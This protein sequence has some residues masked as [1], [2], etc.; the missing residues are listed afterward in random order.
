MAISRAKTLLQPWTPGTTSAGTQG[1]TPDTE[2][3][4]QPPSP[5]PWE[6]PPAP[7]KRYRPGLDGLRALAII[8]V[9]LYH[10]GV[11]WVPGGLLG[12]DLF[13]VVSGFLITS[14]LI[15]EIQKTGRI[16]LAAFYRRR[17]LRLLPALALVLVVTSLAL[18]LF[19]PREVARFR[20][21]LVAS[22]GYV[23]N[24][25]FIVRHQSYF[26]A[27][28]RPSPFQHLWS[29]AVE[30]Q[31]Y[32]VAPLGLLALRNKFSSRRGLLQTAALAVG[33]ACASAVVMAV[34][35][36]QHNL[37]YGAD[38]S[39]VYFGTDTHAS[40]LLIGVAAAALLAATRGS[41]WQLPAS[42]RAAKALDAAGLASLAIMV[43][44]MLRTTEFSPG[45]YRGGFWAFS[46]VAGVAAVAVSRPGGRLESALGG[47]SLRWVG[48]RSYGLY[49]WHWPVFVFTR[50]QLDVPFAGTADVVLRL[51]L[52]VGL[53]EASYRL[54]ERPIR[55]T[56]VRAWLGA[57]ILRGSEAAVALRASAIQARSRWATRSA[58]VVRRL[59]QVP[60]GQYFFAGLG[61]LAILLLVGLG[62][63]RS[64]T[65]PVWNAASARRVALRTPRS[66]SARGSSRTANQGPV[67]APNPTKAAP[68]S[69]AT[70]ATPPAP[71][72]TPKADPPPSP[73]ATPEPT[74]T[75]R[76]F[77]VI[78]DSVML[79]AQDVLRQALPGAYV[80]AVEGRQAST[81]FGLMNSLI[82]SGRVGTDVILHIGTNGTIEPAALDAL[83]ARLGNRR[84]VI[85]T[86]HVPR[87]WQDL[88]NQILTEAA[89]NRPN[90]HLVDWNAAASAHPEW[91]WPDGIHLRPVGATAY[92]D[93][94]VGAL[95]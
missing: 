35:A 17:A 10:A 88:N 44:A 95:K 87:P 70:A 20:G 46:A 8:G 63:Y 16:A 3:T 52:V 59:R 49:L 93:L 65:S 40:G 4:K 84:I 29:L 45:L 53:A 77:T 30:E 76:T 22:L 75:P 83:L 12:V 2:R 72:A 73:T 92:R 11:E 82:G 48:S 86:D 62:P 25:W 24:W 43:W 58:P 68:A 19:W 27:S 21:D 28:G 13:F 94:I 69:T 41:L 33:G 74:P 6:K 80:D 34:M 78:G 39:R 42:R 81:A 55:T 31:F 1:W 7:N 5:R 37:P 36:I 66:G 91:L 64:G 26:I 85:V 71:S 18:M 60:T 89:L 38:S 67:Q 32:L 57:L 51:I 15:S 61:L 23:T 9:L 54:V 14:L 79:G 56:G 47:R 50:P 90:I